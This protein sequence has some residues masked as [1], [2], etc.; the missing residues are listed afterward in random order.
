[1][2]S[3]AELALTRS[4]AEILEERGFIATGEALGD[5]LV[6]VEITNWTDDGQGRTKYVNVIPGDHGLPSH[7]VLG[8]IEVCGNLLDFSD[9]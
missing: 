6:M 3:E 4:I 5:Y 2:P 9:E 8:L 7:R 1:M